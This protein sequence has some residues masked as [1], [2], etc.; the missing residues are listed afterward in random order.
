VKK[1]LL[2]WRDKS[3]LKRLWRNQNTRFFIQK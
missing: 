2:F 1:K 3:D